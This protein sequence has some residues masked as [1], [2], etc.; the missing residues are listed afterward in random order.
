MVYLF[1][2][3]SAACTEMI[4]NVQHIVQEEKGKTS[5]MVYIIIACIL[6]VDFILF[7]IFIIHSYFM[8]RKEMNFF[9]SLFASM[10]IKQ[11]N[12]ILKKENIIHIDEATNEEII[13]K[14]NVFNINESH[15]APS[16]YYCLPIA[17]LS[18]WCLILIPIPIIWILLGFHTHIN[19]SLFV[20]RSLY[21]STKVI[22]CFGNVALYAFRTVTKFLEFKDFKE[23][24][25]NNEYMF[26]YY[27][28]LFFGYQYKVYDIEQ[29]EYQDSLVGQY[30]DEILQVR[31]DEIIDKNNCSFVSTDDIDPKCITFHDSIFYLYNHVNR[32]MDLIERNASTDPNLREFHY[33]TD[34]NGVKK[35]RYGLG[36]NWWRKFYKFVEASLDY[37]I[38]SFYNLFE[39]IIQKQQNQ[40]ELFLLLG[41][42]LGIFFFVFMN[43]F[44]WNYCFHKLKKNLKSMLRPILLMGVEPIMESPIIVKFLQGDYDTS[45]RIS[46]SITD[47]KKLLKVQEGSIPLLNYILEGVLVCSADGIIIASNKNYHSMMGNT[48]EDVLGLNVRSVLPDTLNPIFEAMDVI[49][50]G[51]VLEQTITLETIF[52][53]EEGKKLN[54][55][56]SLVVKLDVGEGGN[57]Q[58]TCGLIISDR[59]DLI[60]AQ[61]Q[62]LEEKKTVEQLL[63]TILPHNIAVSLLNGNRDISFEVEKALVLF[64]DIVSFT[65]MSS[66]MTA[67]QVMTML[68]LLFTD[69]DTDLATFKRVTKLKTIGDAYVCAA[70]IFEGDGPIEEAATEIVTFATHMQQII[71]RLNAKHGYKIHMRIGIDAGGP[72]I[73]GVLGKEKPLF[74][75][76]GET[77]NISEEL[78]A[79]SLHDK[80]HISEAVVALIEGRGFKMEPRNPPVKVIGIPEGATTYTIIQ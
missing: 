79:S 45:S 14:P 60:T 42:V 30:P 50:N 67:K 2:A 40:M 75:V 17:L 9:I 1:K 80:V 35:R 55:R 43:F 24:R 25:S 77:V 57:K 76:I 72:L 36:T 62:L 71:P 33:Y 8:V 31:I 54:T 56:V 64:S 32:L 15:M 28:N 26:R 12:H 65:P 66:K 70:G 10:P 18:F 21:Q 38:P 78:E 44:V 63:D 4:I 49:A 27:L 23:M 52:L 20:V 61:T 58:T 3:V 7:L 6:G 19:A 51:G 47:A 46:S 68:N 53:T 13:E 11:L 73:C 5:S 22:G 41:I 29:T 37:G 48:A 59:S 34:E 69:F 16:K 74:E 39:V